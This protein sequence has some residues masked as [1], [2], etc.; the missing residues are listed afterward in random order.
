M[1]ARLVMHVLKIITYILVLVGA[2]NWGLVGLL[3]IDLVAL[4]FGDMTLLSRIVYSLVGLSA[5]TYIFLSYKD[6]L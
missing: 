6:V 5:L 1:K 2:L 3:N 4:I